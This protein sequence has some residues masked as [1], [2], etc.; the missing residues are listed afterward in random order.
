MSIKNFE[1]EASAA[2]QAAHQTAAYIRISL[3]LRVISLCLF[4]R[5]P[6]PSSCVR[7]LLLH[8]KQHFTASRRV[9][10]GDDITGK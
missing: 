4:L 10:D 3:I 8:Q 1:M 2:Q 9:A 5:M 6:P 7:S